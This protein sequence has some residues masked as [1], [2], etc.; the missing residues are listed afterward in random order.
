MGFEGEATAN[1]TCRGCR[2]FGRPASESVRANVTGSASG[3]VS[4]MSPTGSSVAHEV[5][6]ISSRT[7][8][9]QWPCAA[10][11]IVILSESKTI[12]CTT[13]SS[14]QIPSLNGR[15]VEQGAP[16]LA[17]SADARAFPP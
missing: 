1:M 15:Q 9:D 10:C 16:A 14:R 13:N 17:C 8:H 12:L 7:V 4:T 5:R 6:P 11:V 3:I 2:P